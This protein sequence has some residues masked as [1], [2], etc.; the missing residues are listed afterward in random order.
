MF[1]QFKKSKI[2][3]DCF[4]HSE[5]AYELYKIRSAK[6]YYPEH[7]KKLDAGIDIRDSNTNILYSRP[8][9]KRCVAISDL[10]K[11][12]FIIPFWM[13]YIS[14]PI[15]YAQNKSALGTTD[16]WNQNSII[17]HPQ[18]QYPGILN[19]YTH[20]KFRGVW[21]C[22]EKTGVDFLWN[23]AAWNINNDIEKYVIPPGV[24]NFKDQ[25]ETNLNM[26]IH[27]STER[28]TLTAGTPLIHLIPLS[29]KNV[30]FKCHLISYDEWISKI[31]YPSDVPTIQDG[32]RINRWHKDRE[33]AK[34]LDQLENKGK[35]PLGFTK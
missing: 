26:F 22:V 12:G 1:F 23:P 13:D 8:T 17:S 15:E 3:V 7:I 24:T 4:T 33:R 18:V 19:N 30:D 31:P 28:F 25:C 34:E 2:T 29:E 27:K 21:H 11:K 10:Y 16:T 9:I 14:Q 20:V 5:S 6:V 32:T 35:C